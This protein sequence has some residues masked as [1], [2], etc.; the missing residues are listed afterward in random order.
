MCVDTDNYVYVCICTYFIHCLTLMKST[1]K[2]INPRIQREVFC[3]Q[4]TT[5]STTPIECVLVTIN[6]IFYALTPCHPQDWW[7]SRD[8][9]EYLRK[10]NPGVLDWLKN[11][12]YHHLR[13]WTHPLLAILLVL[14]MSAIGHDVLVGSGVGFFAPFFVMEYALGGV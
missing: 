8:I 11:Y 10:W 5:E 4:S 9:S 14:L 7:N 6:F 12:V 1:L 2:C 3:V 13:K